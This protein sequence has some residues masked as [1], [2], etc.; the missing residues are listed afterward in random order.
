MNSGF[1]SSLTLTED[2]ANLG[3]ACG[4]TADEK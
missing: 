2:K 1:F 3:G 4:A